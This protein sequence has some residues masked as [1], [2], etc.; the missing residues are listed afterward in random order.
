MNEKINSSNDLKRIKARR[1]Y[2]YQFY[3]KK[4]TAAMAGV[5]DKTLLVWIKKYGWQE[6]REAAANKR[7][8]GLKEQPITPTTV[9]EDLMGYIEENS[10][11]IA[12][13]VNPIV[14]NYLKQLSGL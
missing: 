6:E 9:I 12:K 13:Q 1:L 7:I 4:D 11:K 5:T 3:S 14:K 8:T 10:P 2:V